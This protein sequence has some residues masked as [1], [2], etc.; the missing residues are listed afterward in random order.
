ME[1]QRKAS[2]QDSI[3]VAWIPP[4]LETIHASVSVTTTRCHSGLGVKFQQVS[5]DHH[6]MV[7]RSD[8]KGERG[9]SPGLMSGERGTLPCELSHDAFDVSYPH[10][11]RQ[12]PVKA[13][14]SDNFVCEW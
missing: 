1:S 4:T 12:M 8:V 14:P 5:S 2:R 7:P 3:P 6:Q 9:M 10:V 11:N 13:L